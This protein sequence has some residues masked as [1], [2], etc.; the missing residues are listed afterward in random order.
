M[1]KALSVAL[2][3]VLI[4]GGLFSLTGSATK[5]T[6]CN[7]D[8]YAPSICIP[9]IFQSEMKL[10]NE[11]GTVAT[12]KNGNELE[13][14]FFLDTNDIITDA[15][16]KAVLPLAKTLI[17][18]KDPAHELGNALADVLGNAI[19]E[20][21]KSDDRGELVYDVRTTK[22]DTSF[23][24]MS[25][26]DRSFCY[27]NVPLDR[28]AA[29]AGSDHLYYFAYNSFGNM[30]KTVAEL[31]DLIQQVKEET[32]HDKVNLAPISQGGTIANALLEYY[33]D[34]V[35]D[36]NRIIYVVPALD[37]SDILGDFYLNGL[38]DDD[39]AIYEYMVPSLLGDDM[40]WVGYLAELLIR[41]F[42]KEVLNDALD[43]MVE[44]LITDY[45]LNSTLIWAL[46]PS[47][48][49]PVAREKYLLGEEHDFIRAQTDRYYQAQLN[50]RANI[51]RAV[52][53]G[54]EV[55]DI[56]GYNT[57]FYRI[58]DS[59]DKEQ[60]DGIIQLDSTSMGA[61][62][63]AVNKTLPEGYV[64]QNTYAGTRC[65]DPNHNHI[66]PHFMVD[67]STGIL[68]DHTFYFYNHAHVA[69]ASSTACI[70]LAVRLLTDESF[71]NVYSYPDEYPQFNNFVTS[72]DFGYEIDSFDY[73][74]DRSALTDEE[75][76][77]IDAVITEARAACAMTNVDLDR[78][79]AAKENFDRI[80]AKYGEGANAQTGGDAGESGAANVFKG[81]DFKD[82]ITRLLEFV[83][84][85]ISRY[86]GNKGFSDR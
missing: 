4:F 70:G 39:E 81:I 11:D 57:E 52:D 7:G 6:T 85:I 29:I 15:V 59:W 72:R 73:T 24:R 38:L 63:V 31:Y 23:A 36:I 76:T 32:G 46:V 14:P 78:Y 19:G 71:K 69:S 58:V 5:Y 65:S 67:A 40:K 45:L 2:A 60:A 1:K 33:P 51:L 47:G 82:L 25:Y 42:P 48:T 34:V 79:N 50:S 30:E 17:T 21:V 54:V 86:F 68:P 75:L 66:D 16:T 84:K 43:I 53:S 49:Y 77:E 22:Y 61:T 10:Y 13:M 80:E 8:D 41:L 27:R 64:Q 12:D 28:Y 56:C 83:M 9:G 44:R 26:Y 62:S 37:G 3:L 20:K 55:F 74:L 35:N 18:Q